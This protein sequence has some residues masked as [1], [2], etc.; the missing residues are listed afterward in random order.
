[1]ILHP[2]R[3]FGLIKNAILKSARAWIL[4]VIQYYYA[5]YKKQTKEQ[6]TSYEIVS[7]N[8]VFNTSSCR[9]HRFSE[10]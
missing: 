1:M 6:K 5:I 10:R 8:K 4:E 3:N 2:V 7:W 9:S